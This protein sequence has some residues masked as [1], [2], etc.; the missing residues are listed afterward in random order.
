MPAAKCKAIGCNRKTK[1]PFCWQ[2]ADMART[3]VS[4]TKMALYDEYF[5]AAAIRDMKA[6]K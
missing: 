3:P 5:I 2:H 6:K 1:T 4:K